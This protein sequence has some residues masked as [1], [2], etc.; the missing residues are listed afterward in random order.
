M[1]F[2]A[3]AKGSKVGIFLNWNECKESI[4][5]F[6]NAIFKKFDTEIEAKQ[7]IS[8][9]RKDENIKNVDYFVYTDGACQNNGKLNAKAGIGIFLKK[10]DIR[11]VSKKINGKQTNNRA[12]LE[13][14]IQTYYII[15][16]DI[17]SGK[18]ITIVTDSEYAIKC[19]KHY[20]EKIS[21][22][23]NLNPPNKDLVI[24][25]HNLYK[26]ISNIKFMHIKAHTKK[27]DNHSLG[28]YYADKLANQSIEID[29]CPYN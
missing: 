25:I 14:I 17:E 24:K 9:N 3:V 23:T 5:H 21:K 12:E 11:N 20:G 4:N 15:N 27:K 19:I 28:N 22:N 18:K 6:S 16:E 10:D 7:F 8:Q 1:V 2:Y 29:K 13:A 26:N